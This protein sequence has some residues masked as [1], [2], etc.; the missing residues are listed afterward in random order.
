MRRIVL[1]I[2]F[3]VGSLGLQSLKAAPLAQGMSETEKKI[4]ENTRFANEEAVFKYLKPILKS[5]NSAARIYYLGS[6]EKEGDYY[7]V[8]FPRVRVQSPLGN[9][10]GLAAIR[11]VFR[12]DANVKVS[13]GT[14][15]IV[16]IVIGQLPAKVA[17][18]LD[19]RI[20]VV[21]FDQDQQYTEKQALTRI[22]SSK[23]VRDARRVLG[24]QPDGIPLYMSAVKQPVEGAPHLPASMVNLTWDQALDYVAKIF[25]GVVLYGICPNKY[26]YTIDYVPI[27]S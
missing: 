26:L 8:S 25:G 4:N 12:N 11:D 14:D 22:Q 6:C 13:K 20:S 21:T 17:N 3:T 19:T 10:T 2:V 1:L 9:D 16:R 23:E 5:T 18:V 15:G 24:I 7:T 27:R